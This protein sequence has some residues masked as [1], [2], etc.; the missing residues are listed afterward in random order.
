MSSTSS[1]E[2]SG[3]VG[4][5]FGKSSFVLSDSEH[6]KVVD[7]FGSSNSSSMGSD[8]SEMS[9]SSGNFGSS[10]SSGL[11]E[12]GH[13]SGVCELS[14]SNGFHSPGMSDFLEVSSTDSGGMSSLL[15]KSDSFTEG[16]SDSDSLAVGGKCGLSSSVSSHSF[17]VSGSFG[18]LHAVGLCEVSSLSSFDGSKAGHS[19]LMSSTSSGED[20][21][22]VGTSFGKS[23]FVLSDSEHFKVVGSFGSSNSSSMGSD[24]SEMSTSSGNFGS[25]DSFGLEEGGHSSGVG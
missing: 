21:G 8:S 11:E 12:G 19:D 2:D 6:F 4:T 16:G 22:F 13:S 3:F 7:S 20:S 10:D 9:T 23:S 17:E 5:G 24:S 1:G 15:G 14:G 18:E 25:S